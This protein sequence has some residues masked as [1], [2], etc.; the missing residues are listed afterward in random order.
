MRGYPHNS[1]YASI[2][3]DAYDVLRLFRNFFANNV[4]KGDVYS[5]VVI[6]DVYTIRPQPNV[7]GNC[8]TCRL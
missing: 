1:S 2:L 7:A 8:P 6:N 4:V 3:L 5:N